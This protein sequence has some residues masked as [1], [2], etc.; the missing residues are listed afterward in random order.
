MVDLTGSI[1]LLIDNKLKFSR[2]SILIVDILIREF[3]HQINCFSLFG[4]LSKPSLQSFLWAEVEVLFT[5]IVVFNG[6]NSIKA[7]SSFLFRRF[8]KSYFYNC[9]GFYSCLLFNSIFSF[10]Q[11]LGFTYSSVLCSCIC[12][13]LGILFRA[14]YFDTRKKISIPGH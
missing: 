12:D 10:I 11:S 6:N 13:A 3:I 4:N 14:V 8:D 7:A 5:L 2:F 9:S 1:N